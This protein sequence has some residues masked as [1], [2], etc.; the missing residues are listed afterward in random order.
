[1]DGGELDWFGAFR[2]PGF[3]EYSL[4]GGFGDA[5]VIANAVRHENIA[6]RIPGHVGGMIEYILQ[7][8]RAGR[9]AIA[10]RRWRRLGNVDGF[11]LAAQQHQDCGCR[12][13]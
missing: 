11:R 2:T 4:L 12:W 3:C 7:R 10:R 1:M 6:V 9:R 5:R 13:D 8:A